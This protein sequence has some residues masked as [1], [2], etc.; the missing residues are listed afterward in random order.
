MIIEDKNVDVFIIIFKKIKMYG[1]YVY[2]V[3]F[4]NVFKNI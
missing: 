4:G 1:Y 3:I 2:V